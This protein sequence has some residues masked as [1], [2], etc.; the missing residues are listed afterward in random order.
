[1]LM[2][3]DKSVSMAAEVTA[4]SHSGEEGGDNGSCIFWKLCLSQMKGN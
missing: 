2:G 3:I 1:M 4:N